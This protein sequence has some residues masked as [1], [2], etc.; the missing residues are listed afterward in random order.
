MTHTHFSPSV[1]LVPHCLLD[2]APMLLPQPDPFMVIRL[3]GWPHLSFHLPASAIQISGIYEFFATSSSFTICPCTDMAI[4]PSLVDIVLHT[5]RTPVPTPFSAA[6]RR[7]PTIRWDQLPCHLSLATATNRVHRRR[8]QACP[9]P[10]E[11]TTRRTLPRADSM[12]RHLHR[13]VRARS[14]TSGSTLRP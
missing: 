1:V 11:G 14:P 13:G 4:R 3:P 9:R 10:R 12:P 6:R 7:P 8:R 2:R 5:I